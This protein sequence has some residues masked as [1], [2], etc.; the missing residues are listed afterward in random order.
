[1]LKR[2]NKSKNKSKQAF[3]LVELIV[4]L[5][6]LAVVAAMLVPALTGYIK[7][8]KKDRYYEDAH[9]ALVASQSV[10]TE[11]YSLG[12]NPEKFESTEDNDNVY[13]HV[14]NY[15]HTDGT[16]NTGKDAEWGDK[17]LALM[18]RQRGENEPYILIFGV[19][20]YK[21]DAK[22]YFGI[23]STD[24]CTVY[25][26][27]YVAT[28]DSPAVFYVNG[29]WQY[30]YPK[31]NNNSIIKE[32]KKGSTT[33]KNTIVRDKDDNALPQDKPIPLTFYV[34]SNRSGI[35]ISNAQFWNQNQKKGL[36]GHSEPFFED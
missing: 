13:W 23:D 26:I 19:G 12:L 27:A 6:I 33:F 5:V 1:M 18:D 2:V 24:L 31:L 16:Q 10:M 9:Y 17:V 7:R 30:E 14:N 8:A 21:P 32:V 4:V 11:A 36:K 25:Y 22:T 29:R 20:N 3:S 15:K 28:E 34:V 35:D